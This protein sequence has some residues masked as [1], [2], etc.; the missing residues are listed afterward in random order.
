MRFSHESSH[1][2]PVQS[3][4]VSRGGEY[5]APLGHFR[6]ELQSRATSPPTN[7]KTVTTPSANHQVVTRSHVSLCCRKHGCAF[8]ASLTSKRNDSPNARKPISTSRLGSG[9]CGWV[10]DLECT[11][12][13][14]D[15]TSSSNPPSANTP[16]SEKVGV[17]AKSRGRVC[18]PGFYFPRLSSLSASSTNGG[19]T[20]DEATAEQNSFRI[21]PVKRIGKK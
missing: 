15:T 10:L 16:E 21:G 12:H 6:R 14:H 5:K 1:E 19:R 4:S 3:H 17:G 9:V 11:Y 13:H 8:H 20:L 2:H 7:H 18:G